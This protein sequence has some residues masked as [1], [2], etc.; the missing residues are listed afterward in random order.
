MALN[1]GEK[2]IN[3]KQK[4]RKDKLERE[5]RRKKKHI[6]IKNNKKKNYTKA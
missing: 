6:I 5:T 3:R 2:K 4:E 1:L